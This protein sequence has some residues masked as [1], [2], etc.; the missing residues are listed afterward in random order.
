[1]SG[2]GGI[3]R[4]IGFRCC[5]LSEGFSVPLSLRTS[6]H[7]GVAI[8]SLKTG[9]ACFYI[10]WI[11]LSAPPRIPLRVKIR[12]TKEYAGMVELVD[13][14]D[15]GSP[16]RACRFESCCPHQGLFGALLSAIVGVLL[17]MADGSL[18]A[19]LTLITRLCDVALAIMNF[20][21]GADWMKKVLAL[22][23]K[24]VSGVPYA[25]P[26]AG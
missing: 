20:F 23:G 9:I 25:G 3:G 13:S 7:T 11:R 26:S 18:S 8:R 5:H 22:V 17:V 14:G 2:C 21:K 12:G 19:W 15:L 24:G 1:M 10:L 4:L 6:A 16:A